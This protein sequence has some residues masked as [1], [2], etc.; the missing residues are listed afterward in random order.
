MKFAE[1]TQVFESEVENYDFWKWLFIFE[2]LKFFNQE[3]MGRKNGSYKMTW[4]NKG[5]KQH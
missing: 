2:K 1:L 3:K 5:S 4:E